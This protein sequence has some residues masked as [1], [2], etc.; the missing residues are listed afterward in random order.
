MN[1]QPK[2]FF[3]FNKCFKIL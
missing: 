1:L 3:L 2:A